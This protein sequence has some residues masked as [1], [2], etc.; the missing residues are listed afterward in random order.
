MPPVYGDVS[1]R[2]FDVRVEKSITT[3]KIIV[4]AYSARTEPSRAVKAPRAA[5]TRKWKFV[6]ISTETT[7]E[8]MQYC[9]ARANV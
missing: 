4:A 7:S 2:R 1:Y 6:P 9:R 5:A 3:R 8:T